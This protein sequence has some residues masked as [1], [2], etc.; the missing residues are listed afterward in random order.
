ME[1][2]H[3]FAVLSFIRQSQ[4][5]KQGEASVYLRISVDSKRTEISTR[6]IVPHEK[7]IAG[8]GRVMGTTGESQRLNQGIITFEHRVR[9]IYNRFIEQ[10]KVITVETIKNELLGIHH[11]QRMLFE[12]FRFTVKDME[13]RIGSGFAYGTVKNWRVTQSHLEDF[14]KKHYHINDIAFKQLNKKFITDFEWF[15]RT[16]W[17]C[18]NN[19]ALKHIERIRKVVKK[20]VSEDWLIKDPFMR[21]RRQAG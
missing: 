8:K 20:A 21:F 11:K 18:G 10:G 16:Q 1:K 19:A 5:N 15:A 13:S 2:K 3:T 12:Q 6:V 17:A 4:H 14:L 9:E 7:W